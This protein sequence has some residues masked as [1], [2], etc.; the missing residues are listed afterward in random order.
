MEA[1]WLD[2]NAVAGLLVEALGEDMTAVERRCPD[3]G[4][5]SVI[6]AY[7]AYLGAGVVL[8]CPGCGSP[9]LRVVALAEGFSVSWESRRTGPAR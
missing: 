3:C 5:E 9:G 4:L 7:R 8:R 2:G 6:G 1:L